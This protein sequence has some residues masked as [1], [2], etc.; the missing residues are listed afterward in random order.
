MNFSHKI[1][2][3]S[4]VDTIINTIQIGVLIM[5]V[6]HFI[7]IPRVEKKNDALAQS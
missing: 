7:N 5:L 6:A 3:S 4:R 2:P 1:T